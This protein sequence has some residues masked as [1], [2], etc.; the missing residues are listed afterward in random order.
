M[1]KQL[2]P[3]ST[4]A[5]YTMQ[6]SLIVIASIFFIIGIMRVKSTETMDVVSLVWL[7]SGAFLYVASYIYAKKGVK[8]IK[9]ACPYCYGTGYIDMGTGKNKRQETCPVCHGTGKMLDKATI[10]LEKEKERIQKEKKEK[11]QDPV[12]KEE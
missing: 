12:T 7:L 1:R 2:K 5:I 9:S 4:I 11:L 8:I 10:E 3:R 6:Y